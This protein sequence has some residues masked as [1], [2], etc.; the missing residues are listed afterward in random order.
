LIAAGEICEQIL[1]TFLD[2]LGMIKRTWH[3]I[4]VKIW[5][6]SWIQECLNWLFICCWDSLADDWTLF[7]SNFCFYPDDTR[8]VS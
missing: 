8:T 1:V 2:G 3:Y 4:L 6:T 7:A 5:I